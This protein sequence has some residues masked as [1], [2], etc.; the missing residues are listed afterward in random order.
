MSVCRVVSVANVV[1]VFPSIVLIPVFSIESTLLY[2]I[3]I[4]LE[5]YP[6]FRAQTTWN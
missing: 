3:L 1:P 5:L 2:V 4:I 6:R